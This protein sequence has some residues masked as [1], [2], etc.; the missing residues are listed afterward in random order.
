MKAEAFIDGELLRN[1]AELYLR[2]G[3]G[4]EEEFVSEIFRLDRCTSG[5]RRFRFDSGSFAAAEVR[6]SVGGGFQNGRVPETVTP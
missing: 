1:V 4:R 3:A 6:L 2:G 5:S